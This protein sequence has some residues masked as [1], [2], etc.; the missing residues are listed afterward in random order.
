MFTG[1]IEELGEVLRLDF[2]ADAARIKIGATTA[3]GDLKRGDSIAVNGVCLTAVDIDGKGF[4]AD[5]M[6]ETLE[7]SSLGA[8]EVG[9][10]VNLERAMAAD[11]RF[12]GHLVLG[13]V[14][15]VG[16]VASR[17]K[18]EHWDW[19]R[20]RVPAELLRYVVLKGSIAIDGVSLTVN[21]IDDEARTVGFSLIP[22]TLARTVLGLKQPGDP[23]NLEVDIMAKH[24]ERL[25]EARA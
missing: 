5:V 2:S 25:L 16:E 3:L 21:E 17:E 19:L 23:V 6:R 20:I 12:G 22:E 14:D 7:R 13:H 8:L 4:S 15:G 1:I 18:S 11:S 10:G 24:I 9:S